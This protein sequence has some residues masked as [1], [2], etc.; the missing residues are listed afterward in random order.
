MY[1]QLGQF[2]SRWHWPVA[3][4]WFVFLGFVI[5][6]APPWSKVTKS[7]EFSF[8][9][10]QE[11][12][13]KAEEIYREAFAAEKDLEEEDS[14]PA[15]QPPGAV[16]QQ[17]PVQQNPLGSSIV[18]VFSRSAEGRETI[19]DA[20][21]EFI[22][23]HLMPE[24]TKIQ[25]TTGFVQVRVHGPLPELPVP[26]DDSGRIIRGLS[27]FEDKRIGSLL[28]S[29]DGKSTLVIVD[30]KTEFLDRTNILPVRKIEAS[31]ES[32]H[33]QQLVPVG[34]EIG[35]SGS[36][37]V[38]RDMMM[39]EA[40]SASR[41][42]LITKVLCIVLL[43]AIYR[44]PLLA[45]I[46]LLTVGMTVPIAVHILRI[47]AD[48]GIVGLF[49]GL[50]TYLT[51]VVYGAGIDYCLFLIAR[52]KEELDKGHTFAEACSISIEKVG[53]ALATS[54]ATSMFGIG[55]MSFAEFGKFR[56]AGIGISFG[57]FI[58]LCTC[59]TLTPAL[60]R[61]FGR[62]T[63]WPD[64][65]KEKISTESGWV[66][67]ESMGRFLREQQVLDR[68][69]KAVSDVLSGRPGQV[70][71]GALLLM[72]PFA[73]IGAAKHSELSY[74]LLSDLPKDY[75]SVR[76]AKAIQTHFPAGMAG[77]T[78]I[79]VKHDDLGLKTKEKGVD[80]AGMRAGREISKHLQTEL[81]A[82]AK[83]LGIADIRSQFSPLG[84]HHSDELRVG[85]VGRAAQLASYKNYA[86]IAGPQAG[87][88]M[89]FD[90]IYNHDPFS[91][92]AFDKLTATEDAVRQALSTYS[93][94][95][96]KEAAEAAAE[97]GD[98]A[99][100]E[101]AR[102]D[103]AA[104]EVYSMGA[105]SSMRDL[106]RVT[107]RD[108]LRIDLLV[109]LVVY[110]MLVILLRQPAICAYLIV[111]VVFSYLVT[112]GV[113]YL[114]F[115]GV[116]GNEFIG[117]DWKV[118]I[119]LFTLLL[120]LGEDYNILLMARVHE[121][122]IKHGAHE[123]ILIAL[124][125]TGGIISSCGIIMAGTFASLM[126]GSLEGMIQMGFALAFG[127]LLDT[128]VIRP[129]MVPSYLL[130]LYDG[131]FGPLTKLLGGEFLPGGGRHD[132]SAGRQ[133]PGGDSSPEPVA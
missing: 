44:A 112:L 75:A 55:M 66:P 102:P 129:I 63:F 87:R 72:M 35:L 45:L 128:F 23:T 117:L 86:S 65:R 6:V 85:A 131:Q 30:L 54:A 71:L 120:A 9:P 91:K 111:S 79:L 95:A 50:E 52:Y 2:V 69:W 5:W 56:E 76:G 40:D 105:T 59:L 90:V 115:W 83:E 109:T 101:R 33:K 84:I 57:L 36:A 74:G 49:T 99:P 113:T 127:V 43:L 32:L 27:N 46:P 118:P 67:E 8:L 104:A 53:A 80:A 89:R 60:L 24:L 58:S 25:E 116:H 122:Q 3:I 11:Q 94:V 21:R 68:L 37:S 4:G 19:S 38:G 103:L 81:M 12:S 133:G 114:Y 130:M 70:F 31:L 121:E 106:K 73:I 132:P 93:A 22:R 78:T 125:K 98:E 96:K 42:E 124:R 29:E 119:Y 20:D 14:A 7:G 97:E 100:E 110:I 107:D 28:E 39:A 10:P 82:Q 34:L 26:A 64:V 77:S 48:W 62:W 17:K 126:T 51:V 16:P 15:D 108:Q 18:L 123:G 47:L 13:L 41:T 61:V 88:V 92:V 1:R